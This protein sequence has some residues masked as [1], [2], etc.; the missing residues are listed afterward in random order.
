MGYSVQCSTDRNGTVRRIPRREPTK[1]FIR[2]FRRDHFDMALG[3][4]YHLPRPNRDARF[5]L[6]LRSSHMAD[7]TGRERI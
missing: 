6:D 1:C 3:V 2:D 7:V 4:D 5:D